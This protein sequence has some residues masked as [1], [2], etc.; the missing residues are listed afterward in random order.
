MTSDYFDISQSLSCREEDGEDENVEHASDGNPAALRESE[1]EDGDG[2]DGLLGVPGQRG[3]PPLAPG[4]H[5]IPETGKMVQKLQVWHMQIVELELLY[6]GSTVK[7]I[8]T[9][10]NKTPEWISRIRN[11]D[12][13]LKFRDERLAD[14]RSA[15]RD[16]VVSQAGEV[17]LKSLTAMRQKIDTQGAGLKMRE[18]STAAELSGKMIGLIQPQKGGGQ[19]APAIQFNIGNVDA[20]MLARARE[21][22]RTVNEQNTRDLENADVVQSIEHQDLYNADD[23]DDEHLPSS[24]GEV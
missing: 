5:F 1:V 22:L 2:Y 11:T 24:P 15:M 7:E 21:N 17:A 10:L 4:E 6:P 3:R 8:A 19:Q 18:L 14:Q 20:S 12:L 13:Y 9:Q 23:E 16:N